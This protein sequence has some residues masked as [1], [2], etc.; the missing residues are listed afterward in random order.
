M[1]R[2]PRTNA[3][4]PRKGAGMRELTY[5]DS[6]QFICELMKAV[7]AGEEVEVRCPKCGHPLLIAAT[8]ERARSLAVHPGI[9]CTFSAGHVRRLLSLEEHEPPNCGNWLDQLQNR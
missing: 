8:R 5:S 2:V 7:H 3:H 9:Y 4:L 1:T 6:G